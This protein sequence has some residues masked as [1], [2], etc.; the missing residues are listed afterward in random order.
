[1]RQ[2]SKI[3]TIDADVKHIERI[4]MIEMR[5]IWNFTS[6]YLIVI[7]TFS[8]KPVGV[9]VKFDLFGLWSLRS[10]SIFKSNCYVVNIIQNLLINWH[11]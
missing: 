8:A 6:N 3:L 7:Y 1:M 2:I 4:L 9:V 10:I 5:N 11:K